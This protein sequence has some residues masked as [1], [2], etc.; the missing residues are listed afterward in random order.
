MKY[1]IYEDIRNESKESLNI[2]AFIF[3][4]SET[5]CI[6]YLISSL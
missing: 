3:Y 2:V 5:W 1:E 4:D 6:F